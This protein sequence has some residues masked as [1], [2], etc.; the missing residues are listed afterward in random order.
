MSP[1]RFIMKREIKIKK[2]KK[3]TEHPAWIDLMT[4][5]VPTP[6]A[7]A[8]PLCCNRRHSYLTIIST[9]LKTKIYM[10]L[11]VQWFVKQDYRRQKHH[12]LG[13]RWC[14]FNW[15]VISRLSHSPCFP[16]KRIECG[17]NLLGAIF[18]FFTSRSVKKWNLKKFIL[19]VLGIVEH[20]PVRWSRG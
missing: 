4:S 1:K 20:L 19:W 5:K 16:L 11:I 8:L 17:S 12:H 9:Y 15:E 14:V 6:K 18:D 2:E 7:W 10:K 13:D 3:K